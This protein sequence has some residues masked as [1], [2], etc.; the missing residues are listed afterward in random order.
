MHAASSEDPDDLGL[1]HKPVNAVGDRG[2]REALTAPPQEFTAG[3]AQPARDRIVI[4]GRRRAGKTIFLARLYQQLWSSA[5]RFHMRALSGDSHTAC[6]EVIDELKS[7]RWPASTLG[8]QYSDIEI[9][10]HGTKRLLVALDYP[11]E[12]FRRAFVENANTEDARELLDHVD[13]AEAVILLLDPAVVH[14]GSSSEIVD[15]EYGMTQAIHRL[16]EWPDGK[17]VPIVIVFT[18]CDL[19]KRMMRDHGGLREYATSNYANLLRAMDRFKIFACA[20]VFAKQNPDGERVPDLTKPPIGVVEPL[21]YCL[22][23]IKE[24]EEAGRER[25]AQEETRVRVR[26]FLDK[27]HEDK[28]RAVVFWSIFWSAACVLL[29]GVALVTWIVVF[30]KQ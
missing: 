30:G 16:R 17:D 22:L 4:L 18:K 5:N 10:Y 3:S 6:M 20:A 25:Q 26:R 29:F 1:A 27:Q 14:S 2:D 23:K 28:K 15:D 8:S 21:E 13:R 24:R 12:V 19:H 9:T 7:G 11:G